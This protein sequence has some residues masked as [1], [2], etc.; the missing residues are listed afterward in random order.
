MTANGWADNEVR[1]QDVIR[2]SVS[3]Q[4]HLVIYLDKFTLQG[5]KEDIQHPVLVM[6]LMGP[7]LDR[8]TVKKLPM[9]SRMSAAKQ[10]LET[11]NNLHKAGIVHRDLNERNCMTAEFTL[12]GRPSKMI[13]PEHNVWRKGELV[14]PMKVPESHWTDRIYLGD[15]GLSKKLTNAETPKGYPPKEFCSP[16]RL[17][18]FAPTAAYDI[19]SYMVQGGAVGGTVQTLGPLPEEW[20]GTYSHS[21]GDYTLYDESQKP[22]KEFTLEA[23][24]ARLSPHSDPVERG[25]KRPSASE[26]WEDPSFRAIMERYGC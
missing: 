16:E 18:G 13:I 5:E 6:P 10:L 15:F 19:R 7:C 23:Q 22:N 2:Q 24:I 8:Y 11:L 14:T 17:H 21:G 25:L 12:F 3:D 1:M 9:N 4:S 20:K 26:L